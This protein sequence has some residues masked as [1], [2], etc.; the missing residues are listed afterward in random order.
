[1]TSEVKST[2]RQSVIHEFIY[3]KDNKSKPMLKWDFVWNDLYVFLVN[4]QGRRKNL[5]EPEVTSNLFYL[6]FLAWLFNTLLQD[7]SID[8]THF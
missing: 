7:L 6:Q 1:M 4:Q 2:D 3:S 5:F 8:K